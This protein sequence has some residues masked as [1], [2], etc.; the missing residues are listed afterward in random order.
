MGF[1]CERMLDVRGVVC[2]CMFGFK[3][4][5]WK[6]CIHDASLWTVG[7]THSN[8]QVHVFANWFNYDF[9]LKN[10]NV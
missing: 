2:A 1:L 9:H 7:E 3:N 5:L 10:A 8:E 4:F 6:I